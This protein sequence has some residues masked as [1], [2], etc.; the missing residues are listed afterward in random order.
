M[1]DETSIQAT[2]QDLAPLQ[3]LSLS[4]SIDAAIAT[5]T[6][7]CPVDVV[8]AQL[9]MSDSLMSI[10]RDAKGRIEDAAVLWIQANGEFECNGVRYYVGAKKVTKCKDKAAVFDAMLAHCGGDMTAA[11]EFLSSEPWKQGAI[12]KELPKEQFDQLFT[13]TY[14]DEL[15]EGKPKLNKLDTK[16]LR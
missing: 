2:G 7:D 10:A 16:F 4:Q 12:G 14:E 8:Q 1:S 13:V 6:P 11:C 9:L 5:L 15:R 3:S